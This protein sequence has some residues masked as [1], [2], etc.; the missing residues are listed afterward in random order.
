MTS[1]LVN[2]GVLDSADPGD[3][4]NNPIVIAVTGIRFET[5]AA[6]ILLHFIGHR[7]IAPSVSV[8]KWALASLSRTTGQPSQNIALA[9]LARLA[10]SSSVCELDSTVRAAVAVALDPLL[11]TSNWELLLRGISQCHHKVSDGD[12]PSIHSLIS[13]LSLLS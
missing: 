4:I 3:N 9:A 7:N 8:W 1:A 6:Y 5:F 2:T 12:F 13:V 10:Y 11:D